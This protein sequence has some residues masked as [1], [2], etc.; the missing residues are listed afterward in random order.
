MEKEILLVGTN[1]V[2]SKKTN[3]DYYIIEYV[4]LKNNSNKS[5]VKNVEDFNEKTYEKIKNKVIKS[6]VNKV[7]GIFEINEYDKAELCDIK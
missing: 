4:D 6:N 7:V 2:H 5:L 3:E 1:K